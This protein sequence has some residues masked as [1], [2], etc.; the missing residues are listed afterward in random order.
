MEKIFS[1]EGN[2]AKYHFLNRPNRF[3]IETKEGKLCHVHD[4]G[5][6]KELLIPDA[7]LLALNKNSGLKC[8]I[9]SVINGK[10]NVFINTKYHSSIAES[11]ILHS[12][13][14]KNFKIKRREVKYGKSRLD[15][16]LDNNAKDYFLEV[17]GCTLLDGKIAKF[18]DA[19]TL[20]GTKHVND[21]IEIKKSGSEAGILFLIF[22]DAEY[23]SPNRKTDKNFSTYLERALDLGIDVFPVKLTFNGRD[24]FYN[25]VAK[26][27][28]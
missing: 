6:L 4:P 18:P 1:I 22:R 25:G 23:F 3:V 24:I 17:K 28:L 12:L 9:L 13:L 16:L 14:E 7:E 5:R 27:K 2:L 26:L 11:L 21:L 15:F 19:P 20:R 10:E 8:E